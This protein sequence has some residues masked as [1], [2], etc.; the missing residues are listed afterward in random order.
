MTEMESEKGH[1]EDVTTLL[2]KDDPSK[3]SDSEKPKEPSHLP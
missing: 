2:S 3:K 1:N